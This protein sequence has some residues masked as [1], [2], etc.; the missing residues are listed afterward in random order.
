MCM[1]NLSGDVPLGVSAP[2]GVEGPLLGCRSHTLLE[3]VHT[4][5]F[6]DAAQL[7]GASLRTRASSV[8]YLAVSL[9]ASNERYKLVK[10]SWSAPV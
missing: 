6:A 1:C 9:R 2:E 4:S 7:A 8:R 10:P 5:C 3:R